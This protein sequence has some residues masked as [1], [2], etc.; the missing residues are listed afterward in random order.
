MTDFTVSVFR[1]KIKGE[2]KIPLPPF[3]GV[4]LR[5]AFGMALK[6]TTCVTRHKDC[7]TCM[8]NQKCVYATSFE[9]IFSGNS[10]FLKGTDRAPH[11]VLIYPVEQGKSVTR[12]GGIYTLGLTVFGG[13]RE[14]LPYYVYAISRLGNIGLGKARGK[15]RITSVQEIHFP[16]GK[17]EIYDPK[18]EALSLDGQGV[19]IHAILAKK[20]R[21]NQITLKTLTP[22]RLKTGRKL[23][24][25]PEPVQIIKS[26]LVR[27]RVLS[28][29]YSDETL[30]LLKDL[31]F[32]ELLRNVK[33]ESSDFTWREV[34]R[35]SKRQET[36]M[37]L[38]GVMGQMT[39]YGNLEK[40]LPFLRMGQWIH[41]G[42]NTGFGLGRYELKSA[43]VGRKP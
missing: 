33:V 37:K 32:G 35:Y 9:N 41:V 20:E 40:S 23:L 14:Y 26:A 36:S 22:L 27:L 42:K 10:P 13:K 2:E 24:K 5:G 4:T 11:P 3:P 18:K 15:F 38:G 12:K 25:K 1:I 29:L 31:D 6:R 21:L 7:A 8:L 16:R 43:H 17:K 39:L 30:D 19:S 28:S 34:S